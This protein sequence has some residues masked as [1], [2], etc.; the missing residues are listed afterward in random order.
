MGQIRIKHVLLVFLCILCLF[1]GKQLYSNLLTAGTLHHE[2]HIEYCRTGDKQMLRNMP[3]DVIHYA[4]RTP[5]SW[6]LM[7]WLL[8]AMAV[9]LLYI[10][11]FGIVFY[12][13]RT[14]SRR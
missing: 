5:C 1:F 2:V 12:Y 4:V 8:P 3:P 14:R 6:A 13:A 7:R 9:I 10:T 11:P